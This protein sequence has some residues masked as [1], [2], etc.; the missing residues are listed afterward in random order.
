MSDPGTKD[1]LALRDG[2][3]VA[4]L[5]ADAMA[6]I[7]AAVEAEWCAS[8]GQPRRRRW[9]Y[10]AAASLLAVVALSAYLLSGRGAGAERGDMVAHLV[11]FESPGVVEVHLLG[12]TQPLAEGAV[13]RAGH[14]YSASGQALLQI[15]GGGN[16]RIAAGTEIEILARDD[17]MLKKGEFYVDIPHGTHASA[18][19]VARTSA[20][21]FRHV[22]TQFALAV[23]DGE[24]RLRVREGSVHWLA[25]DGESTVGAGREVIFASGVRSAERAID[26]A[27]HEWDWTAKST[28]TFEIEDR[29]LGEFL[30]WVARE[31]GRKLVLTDEQAR[32]RI[33]TIRMHGSVNG[34]TPLQALSAVMA[35]TDLRYELPDGQIRVSFAGGTSP[36]RWPLR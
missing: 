34:L 13:L 25:A 2:L 26:P 5:S 35:A 14:E 10:A 30:E 31:S 29:P 36:P 24:T 27:G 32:K 16:L 8:V 15:E 21:E 4:P 6:R 7:R 9:P 1:D 33:A 23:D 18:S 20:G 11:R 3:R 17:V 12:D 28:P 22:G 19:F